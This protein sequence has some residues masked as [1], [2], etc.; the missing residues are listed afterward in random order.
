MIKPEHQVIKVLGSTVRQHPEVSAWVESWYLHE[1]ETLPHVVNT[2]AI[3][4]GRCQVLGELVK[5]LREVP[6]MAAKL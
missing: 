1:L 4:Q 5:F 6:A 2:P 3:Y